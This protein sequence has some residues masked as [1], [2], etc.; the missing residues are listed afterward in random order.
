M[1]VSEVRTPLREVRW[2]VVSCCAII[3]LSV[4]ELN[5]V[6]IISSTLGIDSKYFALVAIGFFLTLLYANASELVYFAVKVYSTQPYFNYHYILII[7]C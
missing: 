7:Q 2:R 6:R 1:S 3:C 4:D 5:P